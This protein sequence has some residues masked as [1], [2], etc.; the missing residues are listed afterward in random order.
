MDKFVIQGG[1]LLKGRVQ[2]SGAKNAVLPVMAAAL[3]TDEEV[4]IRNVPNLRDVRTLA[5]V[6]EELGASV[7]RDGEVL[8]IRVEDPGLV[9]A[10]YELVSTMRASIC[11]LGPLLAKRGRARVSMPGGCIFGIRPIDLHIK[12]LNSLGAGLE[13]ESGY[14]QSK[15]CR[16]EGAEIYLGS[17]YGSS[18]LGT[19]NVMMAACLA[20]GETVIE[21][22]AMEPEVEDLARFLKSMGACIEGIGTHRI[23]IQGVEAMHGTEYTVIPDRIEAGTFL[24]AGALAGEDVLVEGAVPVHMMAVLEI[25]KAAGV[26]LE[27]SEKG[28][29]VQRPDR[30]LPVD[31]TTLPYPGFPTD[32]QAQMMVLLALANGISIITEK[33]YPDRFIHVAELARLGA[34]VRK[35][36][37]QAVIMGV[38]HLSGAQ[39]M[40]SDLRA[41]AAL[42]LAGLVARDTTEIHRVYHIDRG[43]MRIDDKLRRLGA[44]IERAEE[45]RR[46]GQWSREQREREMLK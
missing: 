6:L 14:I 16:L 44:A 36:G 40:A 18:V 15:G 46:P 3:L 11:V 5:T 26:G 22:A 9:T 43:Y 8:R 27:R 12:G 13:V 30:F 4:V 29:R 7:T 33:I 20:K 24:V 28:I 21:N 10:P 35:E 25:L 45:E 42:V 2:V 41:S 38:D 37:S 19:A 34:K 39:V 32:M 23:I 1:R 17:T 31:L